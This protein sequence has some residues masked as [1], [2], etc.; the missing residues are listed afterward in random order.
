[1]SMSPRLLR[2]RATGFDPKS[3]TGLYAWYDAADASS[4]T[5]NGSNISQWNDKSGNG[6]NVVQGTAINQPAYVTNGING[7]PAVAPDGVNDSL[8]LSAAVTGFTPKY[9]VGVFKPITDNGGP[10]VKVGG[11]SDGIGIGQG[12]GTQDTNGYSIIAL[13]EGVSWRNSGIAMTQNAGVIISYEYESA[14]FRSY[15]YGSAD[16]ADVGFVNATNIRIGGYSFRFTDGYVGEVLIY[17]RVLSSTERPRVERY[18]GSKWGIT[19][20]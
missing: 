20:T 3:I 9:I 16:L 18:L 6:R 15:P 12:T 17:T 11:D 4:I 5:L 8:S 14:L 10:Y 7:K 19:V 13:H 2:P 1:M